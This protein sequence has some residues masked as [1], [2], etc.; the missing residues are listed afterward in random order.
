VIEQ[1]ITERFSANGG[2]EIKQIELSWLALNV[3]LH[4][5]PHSQKWTVGDRE[6][7]RRSVF[8]LWLGCLPE[9]PL[10]MDQAFIKFLL[11]EA[12]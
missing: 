2:L 12:R 7:I 1:F 5:L 8:C 9:I 10:F 11:N 3:A 6:A 4:K